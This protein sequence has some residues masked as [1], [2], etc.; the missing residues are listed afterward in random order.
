MNAALKSVVGGLARRAGAVSANDLIQG[1]VSQELVIALSGPV[2]CGTSY[3]RESLVR[4]LQ[5]RGYE[6]VHVK[7]SALLTELSRDMTGEPPAQDVSE[8]ARISRLQELGTSLRNRFSEDIAAQLTVQAIAVDRTARQPDKEI[9]EIEP[10]RVAYIID[11]LKHPKEA[12]LLQ[13]IYG[14]LFYILGVLCGQKQRAKNLEQ[15]GMSPQ[16]AASLM[17]RDRKESDKNGQQLEKTLK[18]ADYFLR[19]NH[20]N[21]VLLDNAVKRFIGLM[22]G[23][24]GLTPTRTEYGMYAAYVASLKSGCLSRQVGASIL[25]SS[26][27]LISTGCNDVPRAGG[28]L[29]E[30]GQSGDDH[31]CVFL[32]GGICFNDKQKD[33]LKSEIAHILEGAGVPR[34]DA[35]RYAQL[36]RSESKL[37]D[38]IEF[39]RAVHAE[40]DAL[41]KVARGGGRSVSGAFMFATTYP[42]HNCAR[43]I[44]A[45]GIRAVYFIEPYEKSMASVLHDDSIDHEPDMEPL[46]DTSF[47][48]SKVAFLHFEGV[49]PNRFSEF[50]YAVSDRKDGSGKAVDVKPL[51][52]QKKAPEYLDNYRELEARVVERL[53]AAKDVGKG[54]G[55]N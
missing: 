24:K 21:T 30:A 4:T 7:L 20:Q 50:F 1:R 8:H 9:R 16:D 36:I 35:D 11:Q 42:C 2:G 5:A 37:R 18:L 49:A 38:L 27:N 40:M 41:V 48:P 39:S 14:N 51:V 23:D 52:S 28:G 25:D 10:S 43:H 34:Q 26:G 29:Y 45:S 17:E 19:N 13:S 54:S 3:V 46:W 12:R 55:G 22:H 6:C 32:E 44:V 15:L 31:R 33:V 47:N 53:V